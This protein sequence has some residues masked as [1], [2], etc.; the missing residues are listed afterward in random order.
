MMMEKIVKHTNN[1]QFQCYHN[2]VGYC[3]FGAKCK[4]KHFSELCPKKI[5]MD[6]EC[7][8]R[9]P[10]SC[11][12]T[13]KCKFFQRNIC[14][15]KHINNKELEKL[16]NEVKELELEVSTLKKILENKE[17]KLQ[18]L[19]ENTSHQDKIISELKTENSDLKYQISKL[20]SDL[21]EQSKLIETKDEIISD[22]TKKVSKLLS[23]FECE[24][25]QFQAE[26]FM[27]FN[28]HLSQKHPVK[29]AS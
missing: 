5:C 15:F 29:S 6:S 24:K 8:F 22:K 3:K 21:K 10:K 13:G 11:K 28:F 4:F 19:S 16:E 20:Y 9:H 12:F 25:C 2:N 7:K 18:Q 23:E 17:E 26:S 1:K 14:A 27:E